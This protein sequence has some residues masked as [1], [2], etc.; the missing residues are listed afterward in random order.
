MVLEVR[1]RGYLWGRGGKRLDQGTKEVSD[2][3]TWIA[4]SLYLFQKLIKMVFF[5]FKILFRTSLAAEWI[6]IHLP[7]QRTWV[8]PLV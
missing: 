7:M 6:R 4:H 8:R 1:I 2:V 5:F 3:I